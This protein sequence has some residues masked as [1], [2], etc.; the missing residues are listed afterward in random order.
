MFN[1]TRTFLTEVFVLIYFCIYLP[2]D[3][4]LQVETWGRDM[5]DKW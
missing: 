1:F 3:D 2:D 5:G 4:L